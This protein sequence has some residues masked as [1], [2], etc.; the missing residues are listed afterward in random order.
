MQ[1][2][3]NHNFKANTEQPQ[4][5]Q[6]CI[7]CHAASDM[8]GSFELNTDLTRFPNKAG[9]VLE[10]LDSS[11]FCLRCHNSTHQQPG[12]TIAGYD[13]R[14]PLTAMEQNWLTLDV[15]GKRKGSGERTYAGLRGNVYQYGSLVECVDC[16]A[17]HG[18][19][20]NKLIIDSTA[21]GVFKFPDFARKTPFLI[22]TPNG[23]YSQLCVTCHAMKTPLEQGT[24]NTGNG[25]AGVHEVGSDCRRCHV[26]GMAAQTGL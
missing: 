16:H 1:G 9:R 3:K 21:T 11:E 26:H 12:F 22:D 19:H 17:M 8:D 10:Y 13:P 25:L 24:Q 7:D 15:H 23:D 2:A 6:Q 4:T 5:D 14:H 18:T 20:N